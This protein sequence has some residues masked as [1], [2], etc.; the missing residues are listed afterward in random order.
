MWRELVAKLYPHAKFAPPA[1]LEQV[2]DA[3]TTLGVAFPK[4][5]HDLLFEANGVADEWGASLMWHT[6]EIIFNNT[7]Y[8]SD[9]T[10][11]D[12]FMPFDS[13]LFFADEGNGDLYGYAIL[14]NQTDS[15]NIFVWEHETD[16]RILHSYSLEQYFLA[17][18]TP[19]E[20]E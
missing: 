12:L 20:G 5:L 8:R 17:R 9:P 19:K 10:F 1:T 18:L 11:K 7:E 14:N 13:L 15:S 6:A 16:S 2:A 3:E 4:D